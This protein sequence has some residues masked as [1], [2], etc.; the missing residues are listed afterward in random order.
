MQEAEEVRLVRALA[1]NP[2][3]NVDYGRTFKGLEEQQLRRKDKH[4][5]ALHQYQQQLAAFSEQLEEEVLARS[6]DVRE[7]LAQNDEQIEKLAATMRDDTFL[8]T[9]EM[10]AVK[11][12][13]AEAHD[14]IARRRE[15]VADFKDKLEGIEL[16]R[17]RTIEGMLKELTRELTTIAHRL[18]PDIEEIVESEA[19]ELNTVMTANRQT[20][21]E[22]TTRME[23]QV[24]DK[25][26]MLESE[27]ATCMQQWRTLMHN[28]ELERVL[29]QYSSPDVVDPPE[30]NAYLQDLQVTRTQL[31]DSRKQLMEK[32]AVMDMASIASEEVKAIAAG[33][34]RSRCCCC[35]CL[36]HP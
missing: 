28:R 18:R 20:Y 8:L 22:L 29:A 11:A 15:V 12:L 4:D 14:M 31:L 3:A 36:S 26:T 27:W 19:F 25:Y 10:D 23:K 35:C 24:I 7:A 30:R 34:A 21:A 16:N 2:A 13:S 6:R 1:E 33:K 5:A 32:L 9:L 17:S